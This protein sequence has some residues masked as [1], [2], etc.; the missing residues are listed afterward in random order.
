MQWQRKLSYEILKKGVYMEIDFAFLADSAEAVNGKIYVIGGAI[1]TI[2]AKQ[3]PS[4]HPHLSFVL[5]LKFDVA[6]IGRKHKLEIQIMDEDGIIVAN[7]GGEL[8][9]PSKNPN[10]PKGWQQTSVAVLNFQNLKFSKFCDY[11]FNILVNNSCL[12]SVPLRVAQ[13]IEMPKLR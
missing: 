9:I 7:L 5:R 13:H 3:V 2:W 6:E 10:L 4:T 8:E 11:S 12:R 1:D